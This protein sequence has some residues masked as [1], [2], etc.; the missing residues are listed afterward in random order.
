MIPGLAVLQLLSHPQ[1]PEAWLGTAYPGSLQDESLS[2]P[3]GP[4]YMMG[5]RNG[6]VRQESLEAV[7][8]VA[9]C[10]HSLLQILSH[11]PTVSHPQRP[12]VWQG[13]A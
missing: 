8:A 7:G 4:S 6:S 2:I 12:K 10:L 5:Y 3:S 13:M 1:R 9:S 11:L